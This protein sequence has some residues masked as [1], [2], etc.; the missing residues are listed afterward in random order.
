MAT[1]QTG[2][3]GGT[4]IK[5]AQSPIEIRGGQPPQ[6]PNYRPRSLPKPANKGSRRKS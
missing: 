5:Q 4:R 2:R 6:L 3:P 1:K